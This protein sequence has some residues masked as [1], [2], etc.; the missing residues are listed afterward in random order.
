MS[1]LSDL[2]LQCNRCGH[3]WLRRT[4]TDPVQ[5]PK[6]KTKYWNQPRVRK[7]KRARRAARKG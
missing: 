2:M 1:V 4:I 3:R 7:I 5:C 6:C